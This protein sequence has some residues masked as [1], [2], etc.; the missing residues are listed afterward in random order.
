VTPRRLGIGLGA[1]LVLAS[2][3]VAWGVALW[4]WL[5]DTP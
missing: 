1:G 3:G 4:A 2:L 5:G